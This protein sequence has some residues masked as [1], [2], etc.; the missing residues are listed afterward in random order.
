[1]MHSIQTK[2]IALVVATLIFIL[3][4]Y[5]ILIFTS[6]REI[7]VANQEKHLMSL[8]M[9]TAGDVALWVDAKKREMAT[10]ADSLSLMGDKKASIL[11]R[12]KLHAKNNPEYE[13]VFYADSKGKAFT[14]SEFTASIADR[15]YF[16]Q[17]L[18]TNSPVVSDPVISL[19]S[20]H[21]IVV[22]AAPVRNERSVS[23]VVGCT[24]SL[25]SLSRRI[26]K[27]KVLNTGYAFVIQG[28]GATIMHPDPGLILKHNII[29]DRTM[30]PALQGAVRKMMQ[31]QTGLTRYTYKNVRKYVAYTPIPGMDWSLAIN[32]PV[33]EVSA[34]LLPIN[35]L[36]ILSP[37]FVI[38][39]ASALI[40]YFLII[41]IVRPITGLKNLMS[42]VVDGELDVQMVHASR[43]EIG[44]LAASFNHMVQTIRE[45]REKILQSEE[46]YRTLAESSF[47]GVYVLQ[48][49]KFCYTNSN[50]ALYTGYTREEL[51][52]QDADQ[53]VFP[54]DRA[55]LIENRKAMLDGKLSAPYE[56]RI[57]SRQGEIRWIIETVV[58]ISYQ[59]K[60]A[61]LGSCMD[62]TEQKQM[63]EKIKALSIRDPLTGLFNRRGFL[64]LAEQQLKIAE[65]TQTRL[66]LLFADLDGLKRIND[67][68][69]HLKGD[70]AIVEVA[71]I[72]KDTFRKSDII[73]RMGGDEFVVLGV[74]AAETTDI[75][76]NRLQ[77]LIDTHN[78]R[79]NRDYEISLSV[80]IAYKEPGQPSSIDTLISEAD[81]LMY[82]E[83]NLKKS[84]I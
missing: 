64:A 24:I 47:S 53:F 35:R 11:A 15:K 59:G 71:A 83:K 70:E 37:L 80:G 77:N 62:V 69:G 81:A 3:G 4:L 74:S 19:Q 75:L 60:P 66:L 30:D 8:A 58:P 40:S 43:D 49:G 82:E 55:G 32:T 2:I 61:I 46:K 18:S 9:T 38:I 39:V 1:M 33:K 22:I 45:S 12:L 65:R 48:D 17:V 63:D 10:V 76:K 23:G 21:P 29:K 26:S 25:D 72:L 44:Q 51:L 41:L 14:S 52:N 68:M 84:R 50:T 42:R 56:L 57:V 13:M 6:T 16:Q 20:N 7:T 67:T 28:D 27:I 34:Q 36:L 5:S 79:K 54:E 73:A 31:R 78:T